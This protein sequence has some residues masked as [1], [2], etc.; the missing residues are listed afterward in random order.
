MARDLQDE[1]MTPA[2]H[3]SLWQ[4]VPSPSLHAG[5]GDRSFDTIVVGAG[6]TG[7]TTAL[8]LKLRGQRV[9]VLEQSRVGAGTTG[10]SSAQLTTLY[11]GGLHRVEQTFGKEEARLLTGAMRGAIQQIEQWTEEFGLASEF[12]RVA[13]YF[14]AE[15][16][17]DEQLVCDEREAAQNAGAGLEDP[18]ALPPFGDT[19]T[20]GFT[21]RDQALFHPGA[22]LAGLA[23]AVDG[24]GSEVRVGV[25]VLDFH[26]GQPCRVETTAGEFEADNLVLATHTPLSRSLLHTALE[27]WRSYIVIARL[28]QPVPDGIF[29]DTADPY[30]YLRPVPYEGGTALLIGGADHKTG[31]TPDKDPY[32]V[33]EA[34][35]RSRFQV[36]DFPERWSAQYYDSADHGPFIG[37][38]PLSS[39]LYVGCGYGGD[40]LTL[41]TAA[42]SALAD[43]ITGRENRFAKAFSTLRLKGTALPRF[44]KLQAQSALHFV[45]DRLSSDNQ[46]S[47]EALQP[48]EGTVIR[49]EGAMWAC[50]RDEQGVL[51]TQSAVC[52][53]LGCIVKWN[54]LEQTWDCP[55]HGG[56]YR[57]D[58][59]RMEGPPLGNLSEHEAVAPRPER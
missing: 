6:I 15:R 26:D 13:G 38:L 2:P 20:Q 37:T 43:L 1:G 8:H 5:G 22:Y 42:G 35:T 11:D 46:S 45:A 47:V 23:E 58:G 32:A 27:P 4:K 18:H 34:Y 33:L 49:E 21:L 17:Q 16:T 30:H 48:G 51:H 59:E 3:P 52:V 41:G 29:W 28:E 39:H 7:L 44:A 25:R 54:A 14:Y 24:E 55:C 31:H 19:I 40:G 56:R 12:R 50:C 57:A 10:M 9:L 53:H 36:R